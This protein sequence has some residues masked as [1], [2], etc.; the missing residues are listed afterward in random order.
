MT[1]TVRAGKTPW[2]GGP[3]TVTVTVKSEPSRPPILRAPGPAVAAGPRR[4]W[5][6]R[7]LWLAVIFVSTLNF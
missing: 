6:Q 7:S 5:Q 4:P 1:V 2:T 3:G